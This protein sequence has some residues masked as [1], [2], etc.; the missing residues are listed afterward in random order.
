[1]IQS[2]VILEQVKIQNELKKF[3]TK[4]NFNYIHTTNY[5]ENKKFDLIIIDGGDRFLNLKNSISNNLKEDTIIYYDNTDRI[6]HG[7]RRQI[8]IKYLNDWVKDNNKFVYTA[9]NFTPYNLNVTAGKFVFSSENIFKKILE[10][11]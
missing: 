3:K 2:Q 1:M 9:R 11:K 8:P 6:V 10:N 4:N 5:N 7:E